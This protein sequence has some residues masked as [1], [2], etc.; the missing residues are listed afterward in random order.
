MQPFVYPMI[1]LAEVYLN[2]VETL[3]EYDPQHPDVPHDWSIE[4]HYDRQ[5]AGHHANGFLPAGI[6]WYKKE[7][8][9][10]DAWQDKLVF[11]DFDGIYMKSTVWING[12]QVGYRPN[13]YLSLFY[14]LTPHLKKGRNIL[15][16]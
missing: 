8:E 1:R 16:V 14:E 9:W 3:I 13:G 2:Y 5:V 12:Q 15:T 4:Q 11:I 7:I 10:D 6:G